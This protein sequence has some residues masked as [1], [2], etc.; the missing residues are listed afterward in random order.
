[1]SSRPVKEIGRHFN[2][3]FIWSANDGYRPDGRKWYLPE[4]PTAQVTLWFNRGERNFTPVS[5]DAICVGSQLCSEMMFTEH[6]R[7][8]G[9]D[10]VHLVVQPRASGRAARWR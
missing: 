8:M 1:M 2:E 10:G 3:A 6:A 5:A 4:A 7:Y 9:F